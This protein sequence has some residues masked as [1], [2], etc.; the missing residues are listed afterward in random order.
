MV[1]APSASSLC[2]ILSASSKSSVWKSGEVGVTAAIE[3]AD[4]DAPEGATRRGKLRGIEF[5]RRCGAGHVNEGSF[6]DVLK[7]GAVRHEGG[8]Q[9]QDVGSPP[10]VRDQADRWTVHL[11]PCSNCKTNLAPYFTPPLA[12]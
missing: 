5:A 3:T 6:C 10:F 9:L 11:L 12:A 2:S 4:E 1:V 7:K 8:G